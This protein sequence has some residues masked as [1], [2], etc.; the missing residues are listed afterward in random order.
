VGRV[1]RLRRNAIERK[2]EIVNRTLK[3]F[4]VELRAILKRVAPM[5]YQEFP[6]AGRP[7]HSCAFNPATDNWQGF[8]TTVNGLMKC[9]LEN[10]PFYCHENIPWKKPIEEWTTEDHR[11]FK[12]HAQ[13][14]SGFAILLRPDANAD[15]KRALLKVAKE[16]GRELREVVESGRLD[17]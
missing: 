12:E 5:H 11:Q 2:R 13:L 10:Q 8:D 6:N 17:A 3:A 15:A 14:C 9:V 4:V 1:A 16:H 7:C